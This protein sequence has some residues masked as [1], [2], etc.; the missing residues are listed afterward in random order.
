MQST[1]GENRDK[2]RASTEKMG[3]YGETFATLRHD[4]SELPQI[5]E[6]KDDTLS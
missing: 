3:R 5:N 4:I 6:D 1:G 2:G